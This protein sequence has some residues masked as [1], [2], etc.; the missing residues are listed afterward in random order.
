V[1]DPSRLAQWRSRPETGPRPL[2][3][4][5]GSALL[6]TSRV[7]KTYTHNSVHLITPFDSGGSSAELRGAFGLLGVG[8]LRNRSMAL[9][10]EGSSGDPAMRALLGHRLAAFASRESLE[11]E[12]G[13]L[14]D[15]EHPLMRAVDPEH[16]R[17]VCARLATF[18]A[19]RPAGFDLRNA[20][21]GNLALVGSYLALER[22][23]EAALR[24]FGGWLGVRGLVRPSAQA[25]AHLM[26]RYADGACQIGQHRIGKTPGAGRG[27]IVDL[28]L[29]ES[30][31]DRTTVDVLADAASLA[32][33]E[34][35]D[36][37]C[38]PMGSFFGSVL[39]NFLPRGV[40]RAVARQ[41][42]PKVYVPNVGT[43]PEMEGY[44]LSGAV[45]KLLELVRRDPGAE[46][47]SVLDTVLIDSARGEYRF[48]LD[49]E[50]VERLGVR[51]LDLELVG[52]NPREHAPEK[53]VPLLLDLSGPG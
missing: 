53:L 40:G 17:W 36:L 2:F 49:V 50:E 41:S 46:G 27:P 37:V 8:D 3:F 21:L 30:L 16:M 26:V 51:V 4:S 25:N 23:L 29:V 45:A 44:S 43:D 18:G 13:A 35:A 12:L 10:E 20:S 11:A 39:A 9:A 28:E 42:C 6:E 1:G 34:R 24:E 33:I 47:G 22:D 15:G 52:N 32:W 31:E 48:A 7:L 38:Y 19:A 5:G 14:M